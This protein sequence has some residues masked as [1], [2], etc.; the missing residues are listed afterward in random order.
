MF[1]GIV[2]IPDVEVADL[3]A[4]G[5]GYADDRAGGSGPGTAGADR[6]GEFLDK[7]AGSLLD[8]RVEVLVDGKGRAGCWEVGGNRFRNGFPCCK[9]CGTVLFGRGHVSGVSSRDG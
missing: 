6:D 5:G 9:A 1:T 4:F 3:G 2:K 8:G 7:D